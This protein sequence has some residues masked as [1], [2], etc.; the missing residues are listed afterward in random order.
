M[1]KKIAIF[2]LT[3][4]CLVQFSCKSTKPVVTP[5]IVIGGYQVKDIHFKVQIGAFEASLAQDDPFFEGV[6]GED[7]MLDVSD[8]GL[9]RYTLGTFRT[10]ASA[11][12]RERDL[13]QK[14]YN[15]AFVVAYGNDIKRIDMPMD[16][17]LRLYRQGGGQ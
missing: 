12:A 15:E 11:D 1:L 14:G 5:P 17:L 7:V 6:V 8:T 13:K 16:E 10:Y 4:A 3:I 2:T 9:Y